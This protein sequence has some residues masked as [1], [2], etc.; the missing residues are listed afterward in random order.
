MDNE[1][2]TFPHK[3]D[4]PSRA[5]VLSKIPDE[6]FKKDTVKSLVYAAVSTTMTVGCG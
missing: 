3:D 5:D 1:A 2:L 4:F 6:C